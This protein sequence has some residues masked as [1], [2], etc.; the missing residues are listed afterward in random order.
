VS[1]VY[2]RDI[3]WRLNTLRSLAGQLSFHVD[4]TPASGFFESDLGIGFDGGL[5]VSALPLALFAEA[6]DLPGLRGTAS[7][8]FERLKI[9]DGLAVVADGTIQVADL[10]VP[11]VSGDSLGGYEV[12]FF[13]QNNGIA[14]SVEDT[15]G[16]LDLAG[17][18]QVKTDRSY[19]FLALVIAKAG[20]PKSV[21][22][23]LRF[24]PPANDRG[25]QELRLEGIL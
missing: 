21:R 15:D 13:T 17:S 5:S 14:A 11:V 8:K 2:L 6:S 18:L 22:D 4:A 1:G 24:L 16:V 3:H 20:A 7:L 10:V 9:V 25:Q 12:E 19:E 23:Q